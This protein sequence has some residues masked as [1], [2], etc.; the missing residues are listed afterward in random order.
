METYSN[1]ELQV[2]TLTWEPAFYIAC[3]FTLFAIGLFGFVFN[4]SHVILTIVSGELMLLAAFLNF[5]HAG[6]AQGDPKGN[7]YALLMLVIAAAE[8]AIGL[9][10]IVKLHRLKRTAS[11]SSMRFLRG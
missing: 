6:Y 10:L 4:R 9:A 3:I 8:S 5:V 1:Q 7:I 2:E 11:L